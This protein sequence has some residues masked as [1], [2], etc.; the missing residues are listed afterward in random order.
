MNYSE[1]LRL[2]APEA[3]IVITALIVLTI[4][5]ATGRASKFS[6]FVAALG[7]AFAVGAILSLPQPACI[8]HLRLQRDRW[9]W[10]HST[11]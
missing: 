6:L 3:I 5:L 10:P 11:F 7:I 8:V 4:G 9:N 1:L 2:A